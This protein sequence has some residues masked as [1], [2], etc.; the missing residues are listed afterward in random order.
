MT[1]LDGVKKSKGF[2]KT[3]E[4]HFLFAHPENNETT[5][6]LTPNDA[7]NFENLKLIERPDSERNAKQLP[8]TLHGCQGTCDG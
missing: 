4:I 7:F 5:M 6:S 2:H 8:Q 1:F 3:E